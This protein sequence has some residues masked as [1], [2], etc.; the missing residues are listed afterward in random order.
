MFGSPRKE[1]RD[2][3]EAW[4]ARPHGGSVGVGRR[5][6]GY[7]SFRDGAEAR[8]AASLLGEQGDDVERI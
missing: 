3:L 2:H 1:R 5:H 4:F 6:A 8:A 7:L